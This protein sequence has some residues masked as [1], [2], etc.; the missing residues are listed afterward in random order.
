MALRDW[1]KIGL[2]EWQ[3]IE[4]RVQTVQLHVMKGKLGSKGNYWVQLEKFQD[5]EVE[6]II[7]GNFKTKP[8][9]LAYAKRYMRKH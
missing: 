7:L 4:K 9:A 1:I 2:M 8:Q 5:I 6:V 3:N